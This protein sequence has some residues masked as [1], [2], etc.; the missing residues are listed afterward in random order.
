MGYQFYLFYFW[1]PNPEIAVQRVHSRVQSGGHS[2]PDETVRRR[3]GRS[4]TNLMQLYIPLAD[5]WRV[6]NS[7][8]PSGGSSII[9]TGEMHHETIVDAERWTIIKGAGRADRP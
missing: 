3:Y 1:L 5:L 4:I 6:Y 9:A 8:V 7:A 2:V